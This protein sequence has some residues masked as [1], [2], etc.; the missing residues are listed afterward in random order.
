MQDKTKCVIMLEKAKYPIAQISKALGLTAEKIAL[1]KAERTATRGGKSVALKLST[2]HL[3]GMDLTKEQ[4]RY[5]EAAGGL[6]Q[7]FYVN[8]V[9]S[10]LEADAVDWDNEKLV[11]L[12]GKLAQLLSEKEKLLSPA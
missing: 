10:M 2:S 6:H 1:L 12:L 7:S 8:Q 3:A 9:I 11:A 4:M 5:Q